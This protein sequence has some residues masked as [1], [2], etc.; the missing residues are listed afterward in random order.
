M[1]K[2]D[3]PEATGINPPSETTSNILVSVHGVV[4]EFRVGGGTGAVAAALVHT[5]I[6]RIFGILGAVDRASPE[7]SRESKGEGS[8]SEK[9]ATE[10]G[11]PMMQQ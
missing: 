10:W 9:P 3:Q 11:N 1:Y 4:S 6:A 7:V 8:G 2:I 5:M